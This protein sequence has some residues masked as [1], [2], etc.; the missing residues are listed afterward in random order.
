MVPIQALPYVELFP[1]LD[2]ATSLG[3]SFGLIESHIYTSSDYDSH[4]QLV[5][6]ASYF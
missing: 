3:L 2:N 4:V 5:L 1:Y 6:Y